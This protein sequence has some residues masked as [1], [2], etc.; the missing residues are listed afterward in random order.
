MLFFLGF[1]ELFTIMF[2]ISIYFHHHNLNRLFNPEFYVLFKKQGFEDIADAV[3]AI[4]SNKH[5]DDV[6]SLTW[7]SQLLHSVMS[8][9]QWCH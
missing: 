8:Q 9:D 2:I 5:S 7:L 6:V 4:F 1:D 3:I